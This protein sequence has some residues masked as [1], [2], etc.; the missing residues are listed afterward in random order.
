MNE[1]PV[2]TRKDP[3]REIKME[4]I[5]IEFVDLCVLPAG[6]EG[7]NILEFDSEMGSP[8]DAAMEIDVA[9]P[10]SGSDSVR[11]RKRAKLDHLSAEEKAQ[12]RKMMNRISAQS[13]RDRQK[14]LMGQQEGSIKVLQGTNDSL[15][16]QNAVLSKT[17]ET[18]VTENS[19][20]KDENQRL[21]SMIMELE[22]KLKV[23]S[24][25]SNV[26]DMNQQKSTNPGVKLE[27]EDDDDKPCCGSASE[28]AVLHTV[29]LPKEPS[30]PLQKLSLILLLWTLYHGIW[31]HQ[32]SLKS[33]ENSQK[34]SLMESNSFRNLTSLMQLQKLLLH[35]W[36]LRPRPLE[37]EQRTPG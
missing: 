18:L 13:A 16:K 26:I 3:L 4:D 14:A 20:L 34:E 19:T 10:S 31:T 27:V 33:S 6:A 15:K 1:T 29:P 9:S 36:S 24:Q 8:P 17:N 30:E 35:K 37:L 25:N 28:P 2:R 12:H 11:P 7:M 5:K 23:A 22:A 32:T 21:S